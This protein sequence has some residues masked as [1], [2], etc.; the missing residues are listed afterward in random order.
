MVELKRRAKVEGWALDVSDLDSRKPI[1]QLIADNNKLWVATLVLVLLIAGFFVWQTK[2]E[3]STSSNR[4]Y[5]SYN[6]QLHRDFIGKFIRVTM[7]DAHIIYGRFTGKHDL[8]LVVPDDTSSELIS[9]ASSV[10]A[11]DTRET[12]R[13]LYTVK[14]YRQNAKTEAKTLASTAS[15]DNGRI[16]VNP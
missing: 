10:A 14:V 13:T 5:A 7:R 15:W 3:S 16:V 6:D 2:H 4:G 9:L 1:L 8:E 11:K 12:F